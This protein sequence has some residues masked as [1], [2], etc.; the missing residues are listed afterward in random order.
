[1]WLT[2]SYPSAGPW[3]VQYFDNGQFPYCGPSNCGQLRSNSSETSDA[4]KVEALSRGDAVCAR[5]DRYRSGF[6][7]STTGVQTYLI[8]LTAM[9][10]SAI[11]LKAGAAAFGWVTPARLSPE[12][13][14]AATVILAASVWLIAI[15]MKP[16][17]A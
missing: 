13:W 14:T 5:G 3:W 17:S 12:E 16:V 8:T 4:E 2:P 9:P 15:R 7:T 6:Q 1:V 10:F 11:A